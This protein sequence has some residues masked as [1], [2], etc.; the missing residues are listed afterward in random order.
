[1]SHYHALLITLISKNVLN[2][3]FILTWICFFLQLV[4]Y[5]KDL[6]PHLYDP[7][8]MNIRE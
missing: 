7:W 1:M 6:I 4:V 5:L 2:L 3:Y 8:N